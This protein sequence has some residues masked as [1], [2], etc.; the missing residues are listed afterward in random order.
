L[1][2]ELTHLVG[3]V[4]DRR[5]LCG[6]RD[7]K[8]NLPAV[9]YCLAAFKEAHDVGRARFGAAALAWCPVCVAQLEAGRA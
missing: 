2:G 7:A 8:R 4:G 1:S 6:E 3:T 9:P 5:T